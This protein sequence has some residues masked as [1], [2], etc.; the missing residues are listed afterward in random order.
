MSQKKIFYQLSEAVKSFKE[1]IQSHSVW[2]VSDESLDRQKRQIWFDYISTT[3][4]SLEELIDIIPGM[5]I[6]FNFF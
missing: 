3:V 1:A 6:Y 2:H 4:N 5:F